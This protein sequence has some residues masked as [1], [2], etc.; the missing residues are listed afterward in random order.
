MNY[1]YVQF[2]VPSTFLPYFEGLCVF[3]SPE[4]YSV[5]VLG[6]LKD[7][8]I[9]HAFNSVLLI[10]YFVIFIINFY[11]LCSIPFVAFSLCVISLFE[12]AYVISSYLSLFFCATYTLDIPTSHYVSI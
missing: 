8:I 12:T 5:A 1:T 3:V 7:K 9:T 11:Y 4:D 6:M 2:F 10:G